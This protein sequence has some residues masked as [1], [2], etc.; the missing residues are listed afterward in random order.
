MPAFDLDACISQL[1][2]KQLLHETL[3]REICE[4]TKEVSSIMSCG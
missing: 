2:R 4:K 1:M 3:L